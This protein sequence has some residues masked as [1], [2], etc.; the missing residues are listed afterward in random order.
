MSSIKNFG[1][2]TY[3]FVAK[4]NL[5]LQISISLVSV[6]FSQENC[7]KYRNSKLTFLQILEFCRTHGDY[8]LLVSLY[9]LLRLA[10]I[11]KILEIYEKILNLQFQRI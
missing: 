3:N 9:I 10:N 6:D 1:L 5:K 2:Y 4:S 8:K 11:R 7:L